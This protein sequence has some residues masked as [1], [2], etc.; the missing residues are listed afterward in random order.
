MKDKKKGFVSI[1]TIEAK[2]IN[3]EDVNKYF[4]KGQMMPPIREIQRVNVDFTV[5][6]LGELDRVAHEL[7]ISRQAVI[8]SLLMFA[9]NQQRMAPQSKKAR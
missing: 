5:Q 3:G 4:A 9:L 8:K 2:A 1:K 6:M 7:N